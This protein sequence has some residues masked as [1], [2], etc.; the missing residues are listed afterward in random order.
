MIPDDPLLREIERTVSFDF[1]YDLLEPHDPAT[2][3]PSDAPVG[4]FKM[5]LIGYLY[6]I[7]SERR[8]ADEVQLSITYR[9]FC[10]F[11]LN[12]AIP[13]HSTFSVNLRR[14][15]PEQQDRPCYPGLFL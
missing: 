6:G 5:L 4:M 8:L 10:G 15:D 7:Q 12:D 1:I 3:C 13:N 9:W 14:T 2:G 11:E